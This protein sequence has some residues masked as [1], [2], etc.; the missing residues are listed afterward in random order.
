MVATQ[1]Y[2]DAVKTAVEAGVD[3]IV[4]GAGL[5]LELPGLVEK[6]RCGAGTHRIQRPSGQAD[7]APLGQILWPYR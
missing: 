4:S 3:A 2:A 1:N 7:L 5:P 6:S